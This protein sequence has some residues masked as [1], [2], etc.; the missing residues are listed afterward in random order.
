M[1]IL[2]GLFNYRL[3]TDIFEAGKDFIYIN[4]WIYEIFINNLTENQ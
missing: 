2:K 3:F 1:E 4:L